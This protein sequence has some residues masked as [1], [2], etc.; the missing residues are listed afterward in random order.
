MGEDKGPLLSY[1][2]ASII[3][4]NWIPYIAIR[5]EE[6][7]RSTLLEQA[8]MIRNDPTQSP[9]P[10]TP[11]TV[12]LKSSPKVNEE[13]VSRAGLKV[14]LNYQRTRWIDGSIYLWI[15]RNV[16]PGRGEGSSGLRF[17]YLKLKHTKK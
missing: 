10:I 5:C 12:L 16:G 2:F 3:P 7:K 17:D 1:R 8:N 15:G 11:K 9:I 4:E 14:Y 6:G 13:T